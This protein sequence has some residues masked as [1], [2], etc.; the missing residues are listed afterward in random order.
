M[1]NIINPLK[2]YNDLNL[3]EVGDVVSWDQISRL[4]ELNNRKMIK[5][6]VLT[7]HLSSATFLSVVEGPF[8]KSNKEALIPARES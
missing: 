5:F 8:S 2:Q 4:S 3:S 7:D 6:W 1:P